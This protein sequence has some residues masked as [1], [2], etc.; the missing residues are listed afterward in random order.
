MFAHRLFG[1]ALHARVEGG[2]DFQTIL[3]QVVGCSVGFV[4]LVAEA[5]ERV[6]VPLPAV[7][8]VLHLVPFG[9][10]A[11][12]GLFG[13]QHQPQVLAEIG[14]ESL[15][16]VH[17]TVFQRQ[18]NSLQRVAFLR[19]DIMVLAHLAQHRIAPL[20]GAFGPTNGVVDGGVLTHTDQ[21]GGFFGLQFRG[22]GGEIDLRG[23]LDTY[24]VVEEVKL[25]EVHSQDLIFGIK[26]L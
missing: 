13:G 19:R 1:V 7:N 9:I 5:V 23:R 21:C 17:A 6:F 11:L 10:V 26:T 14:C 2:V 20:L 3:I 15:L 22:C 12:L 4:V 18:R 8:A 16:V 24:G 25:I